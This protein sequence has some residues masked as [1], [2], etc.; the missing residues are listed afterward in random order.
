M[1]RLALLLLFVAQ[2]FVA[3]SGANNRTLNALFIAPVGSISQKNFYYGIVEALAEAGIKVC[4]ECR[5][6]MHKLGKLM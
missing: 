4:E 6:I 1:A 5:Y 2:A 3:T